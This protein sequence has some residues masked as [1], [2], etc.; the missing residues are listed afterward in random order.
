M[1]D[2]VNI[3]VQSIPFVHGDD[4][5]EFTRHTKTTTTLIIDLIFPSE[6]VTRTFQ[7]KNGHLDLP[8]HFRTFI[9]LRFHTEKKGYEKEMDSDFRTARDVADTDNDDWDE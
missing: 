6:I 5:K 3:F 9:S 7:N 2:G 4:E 1:D 8:T